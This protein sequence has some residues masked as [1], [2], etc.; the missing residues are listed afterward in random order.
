MLSPTALLTTLLLLTPL[1][2][3]APTA[4]SYHLAPRV[5]VRPAHLEILKIRASTAVNPAAVVSTT[6][7][8][9]TKKIVF[10]DENVAELG[11]CGGIA[12]AITKCG[13]SP[14]STTGESGTAKFVLDT[15]NEGATIN[16]SKGRWEQCVRAARAVCPTGSLKAT[17]AGGAS[18]GD[19]EFVLD[20][21]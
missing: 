18:S 6:C 11:I 17:C 5:M 16:I 10:H 1:T 15:V 9:R 3:A 19:V 13:G 8:D 4:Q 20:N 2:L 14:T 21:P 12:G 7:L